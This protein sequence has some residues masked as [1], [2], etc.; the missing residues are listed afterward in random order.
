MKRSQNNWEE[1]IGNRLRDAEST[2]ESHV[3]ELLEMELDTQ[4]ASAKRKTYK[5]TAAAL[6]LLLIAA[7]FVVLLPNNNAELANF[8]TFNIP[9]Y[10]ED[11]IASNHNSNNQLIENELQSNLN[12]PKSFASNN[13][14]SNN[15]SETTI[16]NDL[17]AVVNSS[18][19]SD[20]KTSPRKLNR[21]TQH[22]SLATIENNYRDFEGL[23]FNTSPANNVLFNAVNEDRTNLLSLMDF[24]DVEQL[25]DDVVALTL[26]PSEAFKNYNNSK[27]DLNRGEAGLPTQK[28]VSTSNTKLFADLQVGILANQKGQVSNQ[29]FNAQHLNTSTTI[30]LKEVDLNSVQ[31]ADNEEV[32]ETAEVAEVQHWLANTEKELQEWENLVEAAKIDDVPQDID[33]EILEELIEEAEL[34]KEDPLTILQEEAKD[35]YYAKSIDK[36]FHIGLVTGFQNSWITKNSRN[37]EVQRDISKSLFS[38]G[39]QIGLNVGYDFAKHFGIMAEFKYS[40]E[41]VRFHNPEKDRIEH[42]D[43][44]YIEIPV[45]FKAKH[46]AQT[47]RMK[48]IVF[49]YLLGIQYSDLR[50]VS[51]YAGGVEKRFAQD[52]NTSEWGL[53]AGFDF[54]Y[55]FNKNLFITVGTRGSISGYA[56]NFPKLNDANKTGTMSYSVGV[57]TRINFRLPGR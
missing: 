1:S 37:P 25:Q 7:S 14:T 43:L 18:S 50:N 41:G 33:D 42:L 13:I 17:I 24:S 57:Y 21:K 46:S 54:D 26:E 27:Q 6:L 49:N 12:T 47:A 22:A 36:G 9:T 35:L 19:K 30:A 45:Y 32:L 38:P 3:W 53:S 11:L 40:D 31:F 44:K 2:P 10:S 15:T 39:Y 4:G 34:D 23:K 16:S 48:P 56:K 29:S 8:H 55:Y 51:S 52:Y 28:W 5:I 20:S